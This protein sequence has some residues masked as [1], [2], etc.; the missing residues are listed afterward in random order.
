[1][2][3]NNILQFNIIRML[4]ICEQN[5]TERKCLNLCT[6]DPCTPAH[7]T[8]VLGASLGSRASPSQT[9]GS[10]CHVEQSTERSGQKAGTGR[11]AAAKDETGSWLDQPATTPGDCR[12]NGPVACG[13]TINHSRLRGIEAKLCSS[14]GRDLEAIRS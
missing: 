7:V 2:D 10:L 3:L 5:S 1:M 11:A 6:M 12:F 14:A 13:L 9:N 4:R 8:T